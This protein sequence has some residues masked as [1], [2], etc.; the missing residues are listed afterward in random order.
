MGREGAS[1]MR[2]Q[3]RN[4]KMAEHMASLDPDITVEKA[5]KMIRKSIDFQ[6]QADKAKRSRFGRSNASQ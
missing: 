6:R 4:R 5:Q 2:E 3:L 1:H